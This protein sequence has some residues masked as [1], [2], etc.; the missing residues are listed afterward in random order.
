MNDWL[1]SWTKTRRLP[2]TLLAARR[3][4]TRRGRADEGLE[5][6]FP[7][8]SQSANYADTK[9]ILTYGKKAWRAWKAQQESEM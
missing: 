2:S 1:D 5:R 9:Y 7:Q 3:W 8:R 6:A 4:A